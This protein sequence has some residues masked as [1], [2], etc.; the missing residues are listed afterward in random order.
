MTDRLIGSCVLGGHTTRVPGVTAHV[1]VCKNVEVVL[2]G[3]LASLSVVSRKM[4]VIKPTSWRVGVREVCIHK[5][6]ID[7]ECKPGR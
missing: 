7:E 3:P 1:H 5:S 2:E 4:K 6:L